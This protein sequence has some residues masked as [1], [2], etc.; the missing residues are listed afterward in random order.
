MASTIRQFIQLTGLDHDEAELFLDNADGNLDAAI[1]LW[2]STLTTDEPEPEQEDVI[3]SSEFYDL[4]SNMFTIL[5]DIYHWVELPLHLTQDQRHAWGIPE[6]YMCVILFQNNQVDK[7]ILTSLQLDSW[8]QRTLSDE[9]NFAVGWSLKHQMQQH[10]RTSPDITARQL[11]Q[12]GKSRLPHFSTHC[13]ICCRRLIIDV[14]KP[15]ICQNPVCEHGLHELGIGINVEHE[16]RRDPLLIELLVSAAA[17]AEAQGGRLSLAPPPDELTSQPFA[18]L[19]PLQPYPSISMFQIRQLRWLLTSCNSYLRPLDRER[20]PIESAAQFI[21]QNAAP[22]KEQ[23]FQQ[24]KQTHGSIFAFHGTGNGNVHAILR[25][26]L[27]N[28]SGSTLMTTGAVYGSGIYFAD[29]IQRSIQYCRNNL[30]TIPGTEFHTFLF[31]CEIINDRHGFNH[32]D[33][34]IYVMPHE[35]RVICRYLIVNPDIRSTLMASSI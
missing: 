31:L 22:A 27:K 2:R 28:C 24:L 17:A 21:C 26:G 6:D 34:G 7:V 8:T 23:R 10:R 13:L 14:V 32:Y 35:D 12:F 1:E 3:T 15:T 4:P 9:V 18:T 30:H 29:N 5:R 11:Y 16:L 25:T 19:L 33:H 20:L